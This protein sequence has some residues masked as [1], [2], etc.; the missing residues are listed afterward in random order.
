MVEERERAIWEMAKPPVETILH[1]PAEGPE[2]WEAPVDYQMSDEIRKGTP[3]PRE[4][5]RRNGVLK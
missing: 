5:I 3:L 4:S 1:P 2:I